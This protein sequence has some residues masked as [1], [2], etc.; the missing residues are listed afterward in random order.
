MREADV[1]A[2]LE[3]LRGAHS[4]DPEYRRLRQELPESWPI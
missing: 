3:R 4:G 1:I 2:A